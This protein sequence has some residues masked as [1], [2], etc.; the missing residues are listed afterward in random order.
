MSLIADKLLC[1]PITAKTK[2]QFNPDL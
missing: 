1:L 2:A